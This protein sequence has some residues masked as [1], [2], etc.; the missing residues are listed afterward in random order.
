[1]PALQVQLL[2]IGV[3]SRYNEEV[4]AGVKSIKGYRWHREE[5]FWSVPMELQVARRLRE[6]FG[7]DMKLGPALRAW[8][9]QEVNKE[10][11]LKSLRN[12]NDAKLDHVP[13]TILS[14]ITGRPMPEFGLPPTH[15]LSNKRNPRPY[16]RADIKAMSLSNLI[17]A[18]D[19]GTGKTLEAIAAIYE[20]QIYPLP[21]LVVAPRRSLVSVWQT[22]FERLSDYQVLTSESP[23]QR[24]MYMRDFMYG[25]STPTVLALIA[26]DLRLV[27]Y[28]NV[29][30]IPPDEDP[31]HARK[32]HKGNWYKFRSELQRELFK[33]AWGAFIIDEFHAVGLPNRNS[34]FHLS[35]T[36]IKAARKWPMSGTPIG[37]KPR[38][39]W[40]IL[41][42]NDPKGFASEW[43]WIEQWLELTEETIYVRGGARKTV[44]N[45]GGIQPGREDEFYEHHR[46]FMVRRTKFDALPGLPR[47][48]ELL[49]DT[50]MEQAQAADYH[51]FNDNHEIIVNGKRLSGS[52]VLAQYTRLRQMANAKLEWEGEKPVASNISN[53][54]E[55]LL[56]RLDENGIRKV[57]PEP[58]AR[59]YVGVLDKSFLTVV[60]DFLK[61]HGIDCGRLDG[62][63]KDSKPILNAFASPGPRPYVICM[64]IQTGGTALNLEEAN[65]AHAL[66][67]AWDPDVMHQFFGR[68][69]RGSRTTALKCYTYRTPRSIQEY[70]AKVAGDKKIT[71]RNILNYVKAIEELRMGDR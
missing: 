18:N 50:P 36:L 3:H 57:D 17:N 60:I 70:V 63:T 20:A 71:N 48:V 40:P 61:S 7:D 47:A 66:D 28:H 23:A 56:E 4:I 5:R 34:L 59:A 19:V 41:H 15:A 44:R 2:R 53:K 14:V 43:R 22:E 25:S 29:K 9:R 33:V 65:S 39:L 55:P 10:R 6:L 30:D 51:E 13:D 1:M 46:Q 35:A 11:N 68:G 37:G 31:L 67:E 49:V 62:D 69:E 52:I 27:K 24:K 26:D 42:F 8:A 16:Q 32:D 54:L 64:T 45:V 12:A 21:V 58:G 38:R